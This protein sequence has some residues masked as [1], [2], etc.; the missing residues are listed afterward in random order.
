MK[1]S[2]AKARKRHAAPKLTQITAVVRRAAFA[3]TYEKRGQQRADVTLTQSV[4]A[5]G[6]LFELFSEQ[7]KTMGRADRHWPTTPPRRFFNPV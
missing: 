7:R 4:I 5:G 3:R 6:E 1:N 2:V